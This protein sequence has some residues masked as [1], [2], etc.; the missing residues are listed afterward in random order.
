[1]KI[2]S[3]ALNAVE[4][5]VLEEVALWAMAMNVD[6]TRQLELLKQMIFAKPK[7]LFA[8][9]DLLLAFFKN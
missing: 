9:Q 1:M 7:N 2:N 3:G 6:N 4:L 5:K 8:Y